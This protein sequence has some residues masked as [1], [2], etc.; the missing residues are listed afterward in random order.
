M[1]YKTLVTGGSGM[2]GKSLKKILPDA[3]YLSSKDCDLRDEEAVKSLMTNGKFDS[4]IHLAAR[5][6]GIV[7]NIEHPY[8]YF[9]DNV[10]MNTNMVKWS[11][12]T[13]V[14]RFIGVLSTC[15]YPDSVDEYPMTEEDIHRGPL[16]PTNFS[17]GYS[18]RLLAVQIDACNKQHG[19]NYQYLIPCNLYGE[20]DKFGSNS[21][22]IAA[23]INKIRDA[24]K[25][26]QTHI[27]LFG[28]GKPMR[29]F[30]YSDDL[31]WV[32]KEC[33]IND[34]FDSFN[35]STD[36]NYS[37]TEM[38]NIALDVLGLTHYDVR[39]D[40]QKPDGQFRKDV[41]TK[42]LKTLLPDFLPLKLSQRIKLVYHKL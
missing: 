18:K 2:V 10:Q 26:N 17:Y 15:I 42:K 8:D 31:A 12:L 39:F 14:K 20:N 11:H 30:M 35:V 32:I 34:I 29:Q 13:G 4:V 6:G 16:T 9:I 28:S 27:E 23:L 36:E 5:V 33:I 19:T 22:F 21:H 37:I 41:S 3:T 24:Q 38:T 25:N 40:P 1:K 7:D